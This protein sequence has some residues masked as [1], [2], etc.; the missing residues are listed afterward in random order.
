MCGW[1]NYTHFEVSGS[2]SIKVLKGKENGEVIFYF[3]SAIPRFR[4]EALPKILDFDISKFSADS[5]VVFVSYA[6]LIIVSHCCI[7]PVC[8]NFH[9]NIKN[10][11][12]RWP[13][14]QISK[15]ARNIFNTN[16]YTL[17]YKNLNFWGENG[18]MRLWII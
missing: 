8:W 6:H 12:I 4:V 10:A 9:I 16:M 18:G 13:F 17:R 14:C 7:R 11:Q 5:E 2:I 3:L 1:K 15:F